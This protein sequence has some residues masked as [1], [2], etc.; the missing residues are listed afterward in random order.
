MQMPEIYNRRQGLWRCTKLLSLLI[1]T[2]ILFLI[3]N[4][5]ALNDFY[6]DCSKSYNYTNDLTEAVLLTPLNYDC[7]TRCK[8]ECAGFSRIKTDPN[9]PDM[10]I[11]LNEHI[12]NSCIPECQ[13]G[14]TY[15][16][17]V[18]VDFDS[19]GVPI[20]EGP[21]STGTSCSEAMDISQSAYKTSFVLK[22]GDEIEIFLSAATTVENKISMCGRKSIK[23]TPLFPNT[24]NLKDLISKDWYDATKP[25]VSW[26]SPADNSCLA[27]Y[28][29]WI[30]RSDPN[31]WN[32]FRR[33]DAGICGWHAKNPFFTETGIYASDGDEISISWTGDYAY[34][35]ASGQIVDSYGNAINRSNTLN[36]IELISCINNTNATAEAKQYCKD[37][38]ANTTTI[39]LKGQ[40]SEGVIPF[41]GEYSRY[42]KKVG[43]FITPQCDS[44]D[45]PKSP[46]YI[47]RGL[48]GKVIDSGLSFDINSSCDKNDIASYSDPNCIIYYDYGTRQYIFNGSLSGFSKT[49]TPLLF[50]HYSPNL[51]TD[52]VKTHCDTSQIPVTL[53]PYYSAD[54]A[55][56]WQQY[57]EEIY[58]RNLAK[59]M[60]YKNL[61][62]LEDEKASQ[63][64]D[65]AHSC[66]SKSYKYQFQLYGCL[67][68]CRTAQKIVNDYNKGVQERNKKRM[69]DATTVVNAICSPEAIQAN[70]NETGYGEML[71][72]YTVNIDWVGCP[73]KDGQRVQYVLVPSEANQDPKTF[74]WQ[75]VTQEE[76]D[77][78]LLKIKKKGTLYLRIKP[79]DISELPPSSS[80]QVLSEREQYANYT[81][82]YYILLTKVERSSLNDLS[83]FL[84]RI[85]VVVDQA[86]MGRDYEFGQLPKDGAV[87]SIYQGIVTNK[88]YITMIKS[89]L[90]LYLSFLG[91][92]YA[93]GIVRSSNKELSYI[94]LKFG[95]IIT[96]I[97]PTSWGFFGG[98]L[99][100]LFHDGLIELVKLT[101]PPQVINNAGMTQTEFNNDNYAVFSVL[102]GPIKVMLSA[103]TWNKIAGLLCASLNG[104]MT[105]F[106]IIIA[107]T[108]Y[109]IG[110]IKAALVYI[111]SF[112]MISLLIIFL[113]FFLP[114][115]LFKKTMPMFDQ[116]V[117]HLIAAILQPL[118]VMAT[119]L[120]FNIVIYMVLI[121]T[122]SFSICPS[123]FFAFDLFDIYYCLIPNYTMIPTLHYPP[124]NLLSFSLLDGILPLAITLMILSSAAYSFSSVM[125]EIAI[126]ISQGT[127]TNMAN[128]ATNAGATAIG[129]FMGAGSSAIGVAAAIAASKKKDDNKNKNNQKQ[130]NNTQLRNNL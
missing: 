57:N 8:I 69:A 80:G 130:K 47:V 120:T 83:G 51:S 38:L 9:Y 20:M 126:R 13:A 123:C 21:Y 50:K 24:T 10:K 18:Q 90:V 67:E 110:L 11:E 94:F 43:I 6:A 77:L 86:M 85:A 70:V 84:R 14:K 129:S 54:D 55:I 1:S 73:Y 45:C 119:M 89:M 37:V 60:P 87:R 26:Q 103:P 39:L 4:A 97:S 112:V 125:S 71:G 66:N 46:P 31:I 7:Y 101:I 108:L 115:C 56:L 48:M 64:D 128:I 114:C 15:T 68:N 98:Y 117:K 78:G 23:L 100:P 34:T 22:E 5:N 2:V 42:D 74:A 17:M 122:L 88:Q 93:I 41:V 3:S 91:L 58:N 63:Y 49:K 127:G 52:N 104:M 33:K 62:G 36:Q 40:E 16:S 109:L 95:F 118:F 121:L 59:C 28:T 44:D 75:D 65:C 124:D 19:K 35:S 92:G 30:N 32:D 82:Q 113:P 111:Y 107:F 61:I 12:I 116:W 81:G 76:F 102:D 106:I 53:E 29:D 96:M 25:P 79:M 72:G 105:A 99:V 27:Q